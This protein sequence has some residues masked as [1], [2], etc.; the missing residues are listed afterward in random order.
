M[1]HL[2][3]F[4]LFVSFFAFPAGQTRAQDDAA[5]YSITDVPADVTADSA[6]HARDQAIAQAQRLAFNQLLDRLGASVTVAKKLSDDDIAALVKSF[7]VQNERTSAVRY[8]GSF[9]VQFRPGAVRTYLA[10]HNATYSEAKSSKPMLVLPVLNSGGK[11]IL[12]ED[13]TKWHTVWE[14]NAA[15]SGLVPIIVPTGSLEDIAIISTVEATEGKNS[16]I[17]AII[18]KYQALGAVVTIMTADLD[19]PGSGFKIDIASYDADGNAT[20]ASA[21]T[22]PAATTK[23]G[24]DDAL[25]QAVQQ[26]RRKMEKEWQK[27]SQAPSSVQV[28]DDAVPGAPTSKP[29]PALSKEPA[30]YLPVTVA[31]NSLPEWAQIRR[32]LDSI[33]LVAHI[34]VISLQRGTANIEIQ[35][36]GSL[37]ALQFALNQ[38]NLFLKQDALNQVWTIRPMQINGGY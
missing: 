31:I 33:P 11:T 8:I 4:L 5:L 21:I 37:D 35:F 7:E 20:D 22:L 2:L 18:D 23:S 3:I 10:N 30:T 38:Q 9:T 1:R 24:I 14:N 13:K 12:W 28:M 29:D 16:A 32:K 27:E 26:V 15:V 19:K 34:E 17:K 25:A 6:A 36:H